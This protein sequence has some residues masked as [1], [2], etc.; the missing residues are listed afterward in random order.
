MANKKTVMGR[1]LNSLL[2]DAARGRSRPRADE[3]PVDDV[4]AA[5]SHQADEVDVQ[6]SGSDA[7]HRR[8]PDLR[9]VPSASADTAGL[10]V[11]VASTEE[12]AREGDQL[13]LIGVDRIRRGA[14]QPRR[15]FDEALLQELADSLKAQGLIQPILVRE[16]DGAY[17]LIA[18]ERRW[19][20]A[21][22]AGLHEIPAIVRELEDRKVAAV[23]LTGSTR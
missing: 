9:A 20:A 23:S 17:E 13:K 4:A 18:G 2:G 5:V 14:F 15:H 7:A 16:R 22:L 1:G 8:A 12:Q 10:S 11:A 19:R 21:Q 6:E 3:P